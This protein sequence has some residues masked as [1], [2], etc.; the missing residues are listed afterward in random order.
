M[1]LACWRCRKLTRQS[2]CQAGM[3]GN[4]KRA[5]SPSRTSLG[6]SCRLDLSNLLIAS[7]GHDCLSC[8]GALQLSGQTGWEDG[9]PM[10]WT[11]NLGP[12]PALPALVIQYDRTGDESLH[13][14]ED[15]HPHGPGDRN[16]FASQILSMSLQ[17]S[18]L[19][20]VN[21][22]FQCHGLSLLD[23]TQT[24]CLTNAINRLRQKAP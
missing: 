21:V 14:T 12:I 5:Q 24:P 22:C 4:M 15:D 23:R 20:P 3:L 8:G 16:D 18:H 2:H 9:Q 13:C 1:S 11:T 19:T 10:P 6:V 17:H 7:A